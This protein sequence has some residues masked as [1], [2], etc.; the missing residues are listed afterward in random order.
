MLLKLINIHHTV[1]SRFD[2]IYEPLEQTVKCTKENIKIRKNMIHLKLFEN[3][4]ESLNYELKFSL[5][6]AQCLLQ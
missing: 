3:S 2:E 6:S 5:Q 4:F 1:P